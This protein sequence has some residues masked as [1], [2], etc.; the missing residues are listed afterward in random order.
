MIFDTTEL[1][2]RI[3][4]GGARADVTFALG[5][6]TSDLLLP[7]RLDR[8]DKRLRAYRPPN[9]HTFVHNSIEV[10]VREQARTQNT[11]YPLPAEFSLDKMTEIFR[12]VDEVRY[13]KTF[14]GAEAARIATRIDAGEWLYQDA[15]RSYWLTYRPLLEWPEP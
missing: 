13:S 12:N 1:R 7:A 11:H 8:L 2:L 6:P 4:N 15:R 5:Y 9:A 10:V 14:S 3:R